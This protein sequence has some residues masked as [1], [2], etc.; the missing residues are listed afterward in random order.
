MSLVL[1]RGS[2]LGLVA[3]VV[4]SGSAAMSNVRGASG[5]GT[6]AAQGARNVDWPW[7]GNTSDNTHYSPLA[8]I[9]AGNVSKLGVAWT[10][11]EGKDLAIWETDPIVI[12]GIM[13]LTTNTDQV[14]AV[15][16]A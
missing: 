13:Y 3:L 5:H 15:N 6:I 8:Q 10:M 16:A 1:R 7:F 4:L 9:N 2:V 11:Q 12:N 14:M